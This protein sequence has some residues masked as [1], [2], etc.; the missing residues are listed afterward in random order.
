MS[1]AAPTDQTPNAATRLEVKVDAPLVS[2]R[3]FIER[4]AAMIDMVNAVAMQMRGNRATRRP[5]QWIIRELRMGS[6]VLVAERDADDRAWDEPAVAR[7]VTAAREGFLSLARPDGPRPAYFSV[8]ALKSA[9]R[10]SKAP[11]PKRAGHVWLMMGGARV[12]PSPH[13]GVRIGQIAAARLQSIGSIEG[14]L[15]DLSARDGYSIAIQERRTGREVRCVFPETMKARVRELFD[16]QVAAR[17]VIWS[18]ED[19]TRVELELRQIDPLPAKD[20]LP[21]S[22][23][24]RGILRGAVHA[25]K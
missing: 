21:T 18:R 5:P 16:E 11:S 8:H 15:I 6:A 9:K 7:A 12:E 13:I 3:E 24:V 20:T 4:A 23:D 25:A 22:A 2:A 17:G 10:L 1:T 19:G 14:K